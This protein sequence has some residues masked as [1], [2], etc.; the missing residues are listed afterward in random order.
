MVIQC[1]I[2]F[3]NKNIYL[4]ITSNF[5]KVVEAEQSDELNTKVQQSKQQMLINQLG[6]W[7]YG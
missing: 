5:G 4:A 2:N 3:L 6:C 7:I 1:Y